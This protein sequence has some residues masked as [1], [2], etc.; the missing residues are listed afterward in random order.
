MERPSATNFRLTYTYPLFMRICILAA[1]SDSSR[2]GQWVTIPF[3][4]DPMSTYA[5]FTVTIAKLKSI[6]NQSSSATRMSILSPTW[7]GPL[8][9]SLPINNIS[10]L[11]SIDLTTQLPRCTPQ[12]SYHE[13]LNT[14]KVWAQ[15]LGFRHEQI[16]TH[17]LRRGLSSDWAL[18]DIPP[19]IRRMHGRWRSPQVADSYIGTETQSHLSLGAF[20][21]A[22]GTLT[23]SQLCSAKFARHESC[24]KAHSTASSWDSP[25]ALPMYNLHN[26]P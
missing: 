20:L 8:P 26:R 19:H 1:K 22:R 5:L 15:P 11:M 24:P 21:T 10:L 18:L 13:F 6:W 2:S 14:L 4:L 17:S 25:D 23:H 3:F 9:L 7:T 16:G 12:V